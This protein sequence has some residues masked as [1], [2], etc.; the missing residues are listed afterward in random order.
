MSDRME[1]GGEGCAR[2]RGRLERLLDGGLEPLEAALD[3]GHLEACPG[4]RA[5]AHSWRDLL[6]ALR[7]AASPPSGQVERVVHDVLAVVEER[8]AARRSPTRG[9]WPLV[10]AAA[11]LVLALA[12]WGSDPR[13][14]VPMRADAAS[15]FSGALEVLPTWSQVSTG[16]RQ[17]TR[18]WS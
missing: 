5:A 13:P 4:C 7:R 18:R 14:Y 3:R 15:R 12:W 11:A 17:L 6:E 2:V 9:R 10:A 1:N 16:V 8:A